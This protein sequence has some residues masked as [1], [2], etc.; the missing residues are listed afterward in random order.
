MEEEEEEE[1]S[2]HGD[3]VVMEVVGVEEYEAGDDAWLEYDVMT[4]LISMSFAL[5]E[6][7]LELWKISVIAS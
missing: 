6:Q 7:T 3:E 5:Q 1:R 2:S 4:V